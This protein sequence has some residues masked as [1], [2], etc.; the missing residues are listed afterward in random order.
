MFTYTIDE[1]NAAWIS[2]DNIELFYQPR[3]PN[4]T[5]WT[6]EQAE[7]WAILKIIFLEDPE[8]NPDAPDFPEN[9]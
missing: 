4:G 6:Y 7:E 3:Y 5:E 9:T 1:N 8:N 2:Q